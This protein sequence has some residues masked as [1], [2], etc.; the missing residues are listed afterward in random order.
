M[1]LWRRSVWGR[2]P[3]TLARPAVHRSIAVI[4]ALASL[5]G[6]YLFVRRN[7]LAQPLSAFVFRTWFGY[8]DSTAVW[9]GMS[10]EQRAALPAKIGSL[11]LRLL[12]EVL[13]TAIAL[14]LAAA[15]GCVWTGRF[16]NRQWARA[17]DAE[18]HV[19][20]PRSSLRGAYL[21]AA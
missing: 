7:S 14:A 16:L 17:V 18:P 3:A 10:P 2:L 1:T 6:V 20:T 15:I 8:P 12:P 21:A 13:L 19:A 4:T 5:P 9:D 11:V